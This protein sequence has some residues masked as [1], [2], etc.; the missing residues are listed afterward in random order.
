MFDRLAGNLQDI[1]K[2]LRGQAYLSENNIAEAMREIRTALL[3][4]DVNY[5]IAKE[6]IEAAGK[7]CLGH[8]VLRSITPGQQVIKIVHDQLV[9]LMGTG[10]AP[11]TLD[12]T[13]SA[14][15]MV[16]LHGSGKT[17]TSA[18][19]AR[20]LKNKNKTVM[21][22]A[23]D[24][25]RPAAVDQLETLGA[26]LDIPVHSDRVKSDV[27]AIASAAMAKAKSKGIDVVIIDTAGRHQ[28]DEAMI[29][30]LV[31]VSKAIHPKEILLV[32]DSALGQEAVSVS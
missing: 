10:E 20:H 18:K 17:T 5:Q 3:D 21:L 16:G 23:A 11:L 15:M 12:S 30:E 7:K 22:V 4:A 2:R 1:F 8:D 29:K 14:I 9:E 13:P 19:L 31:L 28:V 6:F 27:A 32:A 26:S 25:Y 24:I